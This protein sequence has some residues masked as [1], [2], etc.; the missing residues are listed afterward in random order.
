MPVKFLAGIFLPDK[1]SLH[2]KEIESNIRKT[3]CQPNN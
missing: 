1:K 2:L 3:L